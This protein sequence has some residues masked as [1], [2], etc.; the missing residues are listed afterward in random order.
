MKRMPGLISA[1]YFKQRL[2]GLRQWSEQPPYV[3]SLCR[4]VAAKPPQASRADI[5]QPYFY[6][7]TSPA[8]I[9]SFSL[10]SQGALACPRS[11]PIQEAI[12][13]P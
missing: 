9:D 2:S 4:V 6:A 11:T 8:V 10:G 12:H 13:V 1:P 5:I 3:G 7:R